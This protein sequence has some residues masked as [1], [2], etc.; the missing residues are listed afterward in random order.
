MS[1]APRTKSSTG[2]DPALYAYILE[3]SLR[4]PDI[5]ARLRSETATLPRAR[6]QVSPDQGQLLGLLVQLTGAK[7]VIEVG[8]F[9]GYSSLAMALALPDDGQL[10]A[11][12]ISDEFTQ[13]ARRYWQEAGVDG[14]VELRL[15]PAADTLTG[16]VAAG[17]AAAFDMAFIDADKTNYQVYFDTC[18]DLLRPGG[19]VAIDNVLWDGRVLEDSQG[20]EDT[21][22]IKAFNARI[23]NDERVTIAMLSVADGLTLAVKR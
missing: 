6:M 7:R 20:N 10:I 22:A 3:T 11:C 19:L 9:T 15:G 13:V 23:K 18:L 5:L 12:D 8:T 14:K 16:L 21:E 4:E 17:D 1:D 2:L